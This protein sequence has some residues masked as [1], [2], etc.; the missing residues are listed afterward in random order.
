MSTVP[1][2]TRDEYS[3]RASWGS[4][5]ESTAEHAKRLAMCLQCLAQT[6]AL[7]S[8]MF[9]P[10]LLARDAFKREVIANPAA[11]ERLL[12]RGRYRRGSGT[13]HGDSSFATTLWTAAYPGGEFST[14]G[15]GCGGYA[16][17][18]DAWKLTTRCD[19]SLTFTKGGPAVE[20]L[21]RSKA[22]LNALSCVVTAWEPDWAVVNTF[23]YSRVTGRER[24]RPLAGWLTYLSVPPTALPVLPE[25]VHIQPLGAQ[26]TLLAVADEPL[27][28]G[29]P[30]QVAR[31]D[32]LS[33][34][35][36]NAGYLHLMQRPSG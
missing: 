27:L 12:L 21:F 22:L 25:V 17:P 23:S 14:V 35:L 13:V 4:R 1:T 24:G 20:Q 2:M 36:E 32:R 29:D 5:G 11:L 30:P 3:I 16:D 10:P 18:S 34:A 6:A 9:E 15:V 31:L 26:G 8:R 33:A 28:A 7:F 19:Y